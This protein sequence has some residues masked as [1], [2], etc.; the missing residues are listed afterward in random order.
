MRQSSEKKDKGIISLF[1]EI[2]WLDSRGIK[3]LKVFMHE[4]SFLKENICGNLSICTLLILYSNIY[5]HSFS[6]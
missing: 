1:I 3:F 5:N 4:Y 6:L 2:R